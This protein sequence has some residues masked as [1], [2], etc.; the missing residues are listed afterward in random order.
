M[1]HKMK[2]QNNPYNSILFGN[3]DIEMRLYDEKRGL[4]NIGDI[5]EFTNMD[6]GNTFKV[7]V[8]NLHRFNS[9]KD[10]YNS[11]DKER[12]GYKKEELANYEDMEKYY[13]KEEIDKYGVVGIEIKVLN[14]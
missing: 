8:I 4:I 12:L 10:L 9:F 14:N 3:K 5:I 1:L 2:L 11:F 6:T 13:S 7:E